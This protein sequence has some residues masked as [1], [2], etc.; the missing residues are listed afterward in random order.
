MLHIVFPIQ[1]ALP[2]KQL[3]NSANPALRKKPPHHNHRHVQQHRHQIKRLR[4]DH[5]HDT[6]LHLTRRRIIGPLNSGTHHDQYQAD[7]R[8]PENFT[9][10]QWFRV[11]K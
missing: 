7:H 10:Q 8:Q 4:E 9:L 6:L 1:K 3:R 5:F 2:F 11:H